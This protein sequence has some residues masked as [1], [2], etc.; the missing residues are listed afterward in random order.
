M[1]RQWLVAMLISICLGSPAFAASVTD[2]G[3]ARPTVDNKIVGRWHLVAVYEGSENISMNQVLKDYWIFKPNGWVEHL[4]EPFGL[5]RSSYWMEGRKLA[6]QDRS[7]KE[8]RMFVVT[9][10]DDEKM[11]WK[12]RQEGRTYTCNLARY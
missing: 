6:V 12:Y 1:I 11:I 5:R 7:G 4:E 10:I 2:W 8:I 9:Y 3:S